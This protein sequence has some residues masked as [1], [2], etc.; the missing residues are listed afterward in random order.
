MELRPFL[1][2]TLALAG[3]CEAKTIAQEAV[4]YEG[5]QVLRV[6]V[7][8]KESFDFLALLPE[9]DFWNLGKVGGHVDL[10]VTPHAAAGIKTILASKAYKFS[11]M[12]ENVEDLIRLEKVSLLFL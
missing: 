8:T 5:H 1:L 10:M 9:V 6:D 7:P 12:I 4:S 2:C 3:L 11:T